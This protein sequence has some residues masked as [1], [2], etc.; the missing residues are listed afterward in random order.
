MGC[1]GV[2]EGFRGELRGGDLRVWGCRGV[3][4][5][6][7]GIMGEK[8]KTFFAPNEKLS[9]PFRFDEHCPKKN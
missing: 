3:G 4:V 2:G 7:W 8:S 6:V 9:N 1:R 5:C